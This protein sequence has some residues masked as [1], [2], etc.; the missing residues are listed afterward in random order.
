MH[1]CGLQL[2]NLKGEHR[3]YLPRGG[4]QHPQGQRTD[5]GHWAVSSPRSCSGSM[6]NTKKKEGEG[7]DCMG[8]AD[9][10]SDPWP[11]EHCNGN[12]LHL[13]EIKEKILNQA[14]SVCFL[15]VLV[16]VGLNPRFLV[17]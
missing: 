14:C 12:S 17:L 9:R 2:G 7:C 15:S 10:A 16:T 13:R 3:V 1:R 6:E 4:Q 11:G 8:A 5:A